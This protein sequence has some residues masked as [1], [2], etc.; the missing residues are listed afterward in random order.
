M[1]FFT[2]P[3]S[4][5]ATAVWLENIWSQNLRMHPRDLKNDFPRIRRGYGKLFSNR[6]QV[7]I[8]VFLEDPIT[9]N[10]VVIHKFKCDRVEYDEEYIGESSGIYEERPKEHL[11]APSPI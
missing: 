4:I 6:F 11:K 3:E 2:P 5:N 8:E 7:M 10:S 9:K 1:L